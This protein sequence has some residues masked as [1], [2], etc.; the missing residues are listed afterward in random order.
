MV[1]QSWANYR[2]KFR[3]IGASS[4][5]LRSSFAA[6]TFVDWNQL[7]AVVVEQQSPTALKKLAASTSVYNSRIIA[8]GCM[9]IGET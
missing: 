1:M 3:E 4:S 9:D 8:T 5:E 6:R 7:P 2:F